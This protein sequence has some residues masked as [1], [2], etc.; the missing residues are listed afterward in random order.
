MVGRDRVSF[1]DR[2]VGGCLWLL[3]AA[4]AVY[5]AVRLI[6]AVVKPLLVI[7]A[8]AGGLVVVGFLLRIVW[9]RSVDR[10]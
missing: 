1:L 4:V 6:E 2:L 7:A 10:W 8:T 5:A 3:V 9:Q